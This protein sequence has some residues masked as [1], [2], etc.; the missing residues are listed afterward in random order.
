[1]PPFSNGDDHLLKAWDFLHSGEIVCLLNEETIKNPYTA[2]RKR[3]V[4]IVSQHGE[5]EYL[6][7]CFSSAQRKTN[8]RVAMVYLKKVAE[9]DRLD[10]WAKDGE[11]KT[12]SDDIGEAPSLPALIDRLGN[13]QH[14]YDQANEH[15]LKAFQHIRKASLFLQANDI[16]T[17]YTDDSYKK[18]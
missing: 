5:G 14:F 9:D 10:L 3:L 1:N 17:G 16:K 6:G 8:G 2:A 18:A 4:E 11:E 12:V 15:M 13:M 7:D